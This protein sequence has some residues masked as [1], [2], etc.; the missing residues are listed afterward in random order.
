ME[1]IIVGGGEIGLSLAKRL[2]AGGASVLIH[3]IRPEVDELKDVGHLIK[4]INFL[5]ICIPYRSD[6]VMIIGK[7]IER[8]NPKITI[9]EST[10]P[11]GTTR[12]LMNTGKQIVHSPVRGRH[13][14]T[15]SEHI[16]KFM[17]PV[18]SDNKATAERVVQ[19]YKQAGIPAKHM[20]PPETTELGKLFELGYYGLCIAWHQEMQRWCDRT[21]VDFNK[22]FTE[23][24]LDYNKVYGASNETKHLCKATLFPG[25][26]SGHCVMQNIPKLQKVMASEFIRTILHSNDKWAKEHGT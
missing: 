10:V 6:F 11:V 7:Y 17:K 4:D 22:A 3:D 1:S 2:R 5:H 19:Y 26:I 16:G 21:G 15:L 24:N 8:F 25:H 12:K 14:Q 20:G 13:K 18:G 9:I 23:W